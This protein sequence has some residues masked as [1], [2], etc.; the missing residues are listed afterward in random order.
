MLKLA[1]VGCGSFPY[2]TLYPMLRNQPV[3]LT[4]ICDIDLK[5]AERFSTFYQAG[6]IYT[7]YK[8]M[9]R[10]EKPEAVICV[11][12]IDTHYEV[13]KF[14]LEN[15]VNILT[16]KAPCQN[17][18]QA[19]ELSALQ[20]KTGRFMGVAFNRRWGTGYSLAKNVIN[21][22]EFGTVSMFYSKFNTHAFK[23]LDFMIYNHIIHIIDLAV[24]LLGPI[25]NPIVQC[26]V[27][28]EHNG[29]VAIHFTADKSGAI[30]TLQ[31]AATV[32]EPYPVE[33]LDVA[34][35]NGHDVIVENWREFRYNRN[36]PERDINFNQPLRENKDCL[37]WN[38]AGGYGIGR[39]IF[40]YMGFEALLAEFVKAAGSAGE[41]FSCT[42]EDC[43]PTMKFTDEV[44]R[45]VKK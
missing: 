45:L 11:T 12:N 19:E 4:G 21:G 27:L 7:D 32:D 14:C 35:N 18:A 26:N 9:I 43:I 2:N 40:S 5:T 15:G 16:E 3:K 42:I 29:A 37:I 39:G 1:L 36:G 23:D 44:R 13:A 24:Y 25:S 38:P 6:K 22:G 34:G 8:E 31:S 20:K 17:A 28:G 41:K 33:R 30:G 10:I